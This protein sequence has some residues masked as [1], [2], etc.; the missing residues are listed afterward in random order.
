ML[1]LRPC[2]PRFTPSR[3]LGPESQCFTCV[4]VIEGVASSASAATLKASNLETSVE[5]DRRSADI[6][7]E[8]M[9]KQ[10]GTS[11]CNDRGT[12]T[13]NANYMQNVKIMNGLYLRRLELVGDNKRSIKSPVLTCNHSCH[14]QSFWA[15]WPARVEGN[16]L[17]RQV[18]KKGLWCLARTDWVTNV[19]Y[20]IWTG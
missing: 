16:G 3:F 9:R 19:L 14:S 18:L 11:T 12:S 2:S 17:G 6:S 5:T 7:G 8:N 13:C 1:H 4:S 10:R 15:T 20:L